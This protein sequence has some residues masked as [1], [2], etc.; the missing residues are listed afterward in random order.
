MKF[1]GKELFDLGV[2]QKKIKL[3]IGREFSSK[4]ELLEEL[5]PK[6][7]TFTP[8]G[9]TWAD[10][11]WNNIPHLPMLIKGDKKTGV[12]IKMSKSQLKRFMDDGAI[13][14][15]HEYPSSTDL[16]P[17]GELPEHIIWFPNNDETRCSMG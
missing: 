11:I 9:E 8:Q 7:N 13:L 10:W 5:K 17:E 2:P 14:I 6:E 12:P 15:D 16:K 1:N 4:E 3:F